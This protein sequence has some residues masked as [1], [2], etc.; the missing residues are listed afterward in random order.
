MATYSVELTE[1]LRRRGLHVTFFHHGRER[2]PTLSELVPAALGGGSTAAPAEAPAEP[3]L[4]GSVPLASVPLVK[5]LV[6]SPRRAKRQ[7]VDRLRDGD[8]DLVHASFWFSSLDWDLPRTC[9]E[10]GIPIMATF[11]VAFDTRRSLWGGITNATYRAYAPALARCDRVIVFGTSQR[12][13]LAEMGVPNEALRVLPNGVDVDV[14]RPGVSRAPEWFQA[15]RFFLYMGRVDSEKNVDAL[16]RAFLAVAPP[17]GVKLV[18]MGT[19]TARRRLQRQFADPRVVFT[20]HI[21]DAVRRTEILRGASAFVLPSSVE[22]LSLAM[23]EAMA[24]GVPTIATDVG[25]DGEALRGAGIVIDPT[26]L[27]PELR[28]AIRQLIE[29]PGLGPA[30][31]KAARERVVERFSLERNLDCLIDLY[32][33]LVA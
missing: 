26:D 4:G 17:E 22:G 24:C 21:S 32:R 3:P 25:G 20:G 8:F 10:L 27:E 33:E 28:L 9:H 11:H 7:L 5:P 16:L 6:I 15:E 29:V 30:L 19:G 14:Y 1:R 31:G 18:V 12:D 13:L 23:L 2:A